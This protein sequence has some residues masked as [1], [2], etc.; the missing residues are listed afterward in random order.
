MVLT[1]GTVNATVMVSVA[2]QEGDSQDM[3]VPKFEVQLNE[4]DAPMK[5][6]ILVNGAVKDFSHP[7]LMYQEFYSKCHILSFTGVPIIY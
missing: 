7:E 6:L 4:A 5:L 3:E 1:D 2:M